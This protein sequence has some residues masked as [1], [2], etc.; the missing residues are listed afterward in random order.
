MI[1]TLVMAQP[2]T[3]STPHQPYNGYHGLVL[4]AGA[5]SRFGGDKMLANWRGEPLVMAAAQIALLA[6]VETV[7]IVVGH[8]GAAVEGALAPLLEPRLRVVSCIDWHQG[9]SASLKAGISALPCAAGAVVFLGDMPC[10]S[11]G[12]ARQLLEAVAAG[13]PAARAAHRGRPAHPVALS[14]CLF[15]ALCALHG[16]QGARAILHNLEGLVE[17]A[18]DEHD[19][20]FDVDTLKDLA[21]LSSRCWSEPVVTHGPDP[22]LMVH[23]PSRLHGYNPC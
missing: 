2:S 22:D 13:A 16:D 10:V 9:L 20:A 7:T 11:T 18:S 21:E 1:V 19:S 8:H 17:I 15:S 6:P 14:S 4:A 5:G 23:P 12:L 3:V